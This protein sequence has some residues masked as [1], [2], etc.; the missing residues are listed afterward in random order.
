M[1]IN[2]VKIILKLFEFIFS[3]FLSKALCHRNVF[4]NTPLII[5]G[6]F[7]SIPPDTNTYVCVSGGKEC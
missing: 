1:F 7:I 6:I 2:K 3:D 4:V 5:L